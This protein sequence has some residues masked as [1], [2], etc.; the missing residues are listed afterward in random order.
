MKTV[1]VARTGALSVADHL[2]EMRAWLAVRNIAPLELT[3]LHILNF[4]VVFRATFNAEAEADQFFHAFSGA[5]PPK[6]TG[7]E[8]QR[9]GA[10]DAGR[11]R[12]LMVH[13]SGLIV[14][15]LAFSILWIGIVVVSEAIDGQLIRELSEVIPAA[16]VPIALPPLLLWGLMSLRSKRSPA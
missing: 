7:D 16:V 8:A 4:R 2:G 14:L 12:D 3:M 11:S 1:V 9:N 13:L 10:S 15:W 6:P 5:T